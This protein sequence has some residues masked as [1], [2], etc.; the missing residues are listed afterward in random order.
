MYTCVC[1]FFSLLILINCVA[2]LLSISSKRPSSP[3]CGHLATPT[4]PVLMVNLTMVGFTKDGI[5]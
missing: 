5:P 4:F 1:F 3:K 2:M